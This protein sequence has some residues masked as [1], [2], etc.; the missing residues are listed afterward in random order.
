MEF[1]KEN[2]RNG[3]CHIPDSSVNPVTGLVKI[4]GEKRSGTV[5]SY[6]W[7]HVTAEGRHDFT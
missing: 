2:F 4:R 3:L 1:V 6:E 7:L 5:F